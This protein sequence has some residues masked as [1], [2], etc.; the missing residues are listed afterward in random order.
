MEKGSTLHSKVIA[1]A[2]GWCGTYHTGVDTLLT[3]TE[4]VEVLGSRSPGQKRNR[5]HFTKTPCNGD[6]HAEEDACSDAMKHSERLLQVLRVRQQVSLK[7][8]STHEAVPVSRTDLSFFT[9]AESHIPF[10]QLQVPPILAHF[11][12]TPDERVGGNYGLRGG[13]VIGTGPSQVSIATTTNTA[14]VQAP[15]PPAVDSSQL[16]STAVTAPE[17]LVLRLCELDVILRVFFS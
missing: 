10:C 1:C 13:S 7:G 8:N 15:I 11:A 16:G 9:R 3:S 17:W 4:G 14:G 12:S 6:S 2:V 5:T